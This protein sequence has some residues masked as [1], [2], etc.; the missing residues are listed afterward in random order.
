MCV[1]GGGG[2]SLCGERRGAGLCGGRGCG[3][4]CVGL[5]NGT[6]FCRTVPSYIPPSVLEYSDIYIFSY[7][8]NHS[9]IEEEK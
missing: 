4:L 7:S 3:L 5:R 9:R 8:N 2:A 1:E 6:G